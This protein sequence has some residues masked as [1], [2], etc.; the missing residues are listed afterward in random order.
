MISFAA[1]SAIGVYQRY[2]SPYKGFRCAHHAHTG[3]RSCSAY[4]RGVVKKLGAFAL[5]NAMPRQFERCK[6]AYAAILETRATSN[7]V[8]DKKNNRWY[9]NC[10][11]GGCDIPFNIF[12]KANQCDLPCDAGIGACDCSL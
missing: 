4:A 7:S 11:C 6:A 1:N 12:G 10:D 8:E 9:D 3:Q 2:I 5:I